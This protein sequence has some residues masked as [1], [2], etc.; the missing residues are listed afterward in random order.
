[1]SG[2]GLGNTALKINCQDR[3][4]LDAA[5]TSGGF[6]PLFRRRGAGGANMA[7]M[8]NTIELVFARRV[9]VN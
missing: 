5:G 8:K 6:N 3:V 1:M 7:A 4:Q 2:A 9:V